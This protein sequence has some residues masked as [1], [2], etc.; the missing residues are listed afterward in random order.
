MEQYKPFVD[1]WLL[2]EMLVEKKILT[3]EEAEKIAD[4]SKPKFG[5]GGAV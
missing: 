5:T 3:P 1:T 2:V 4:D